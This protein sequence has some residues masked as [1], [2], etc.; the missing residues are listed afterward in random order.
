MNHSGKVDFFDVLADK[1]DG[2]EDQSVV[3]EKLDHGLAH[4]GVSGT[5]TVVDVGCGTGNLTRALLG[6]LS[7]SS[8]VIAVDLS[9]RMIE[10]AR[11]KVADARVVW[12]VGD[13]G[14]LPVG[15][16]SC[17]R[18]V[19]FSV[20]PHFEDTP[21]IARE[22]ARALRPSG[23]LHVWHMS[24]RDKVNEIHSAAGEAVRGDV[25]GP[26]SETAAVLARAGFR[27][28]A[29]VDT[30]ESYLVTAERVAR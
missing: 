17:D 18:V 21:A 8:R 25:L 15:D 10:V 19:C 23:R 2:F 12:H 27:V 26:A 28:T 22:F 29:Q 9:P 16:A 6:R 3:R 24:G 1:W 20:W 5:E 7:L 4:L 13:A 30:D 11:G 14:R